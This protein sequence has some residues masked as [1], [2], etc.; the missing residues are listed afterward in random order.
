MGA[1]LREGRFS[2]MREPG[3]EPSPR[4]ADDQRGRP[5]AQAGG[6]LRVSR[7]QL[8]NRGWIFRH[9]GPGRGVLIAVVSTIVF[10]ALLALLA[11]QSPGWEAFK[12]YFLGWRSTRKVVPEIAGLS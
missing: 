12:A 2:A 11:T 8:E 1:G 10:L 5:C 3:A 6:G 9:P 4:P 7:W